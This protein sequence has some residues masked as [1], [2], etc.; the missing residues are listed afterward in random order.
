M[1]E[2]RPR[3]LQLIL[4]PALLT[5]AVTALRLTGEL[6]SWSPVFF[7]RA[8]GGAGAIVG[9]S[10]L[11][12]V[13]GVYFAWRL[14]RAG[15]GPER[16]GRAVAFALASLVAPPLAL[17]L[18]AMLH[19]GTPVTFGL[20]AVA[21][22]AGTV[23]AFR[24]WPALGRTMLAYAFAA[25]IPVAVLMLPAIL[26]KWG[27]HYDA[28]AP[29]LPP[30]GPVATWAVIGLLPQMTLWIAITVIA[31]M[32]TGTITAAVAGRRRRS[33]VADAA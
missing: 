7:S 12:P 23:A 5:L 10:W 20:F 9:I 8:G 11:P 32:L 4:V 15:E 16:S 26:G 13:F 1:P 14:A 22:L 27:T 30:M 33:P 31:G 21:L 19:A 17:G 18:G 28:P 24:A 3:T 6:M 25:R 29:G 2:T